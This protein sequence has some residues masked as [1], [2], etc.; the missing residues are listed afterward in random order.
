LQFCS[1]CY[2]HKYFTKG[3]AVPILNRPVRAQWL[4]TYNGWIPVG[5]QV[6]PS[7]IVGDSLYERM[8]R[9]MIRRISCLRQ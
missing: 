8:L 2:E 5:G 6:D 4:K 1:L 9:R 3:T 7:S